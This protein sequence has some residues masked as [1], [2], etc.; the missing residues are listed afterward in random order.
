[1]LLIRSDNLT[2][3]TGQ[4][5]PFIADLCTGIFHFLSARIYA[6]KRDSIIPHYL[7]ESLFLNNR[8]SNLRNHTTIIATITRGHMSQ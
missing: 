4:L 5:V 1:M 2:Q 7:R 8:N 3:V 6:Y